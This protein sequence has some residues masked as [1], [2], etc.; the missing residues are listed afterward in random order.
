MKRTRRGSASVVLLVV[1]VAAELLVL[2]RVTGGARD[3]DLSVR[4]LETLRAF[5]AAEGGMNMALREAIAGTDADG[6]GAAGS[7]SSDGNGAND[8]SFSGAAVSVSTTTSAG[9]TVLAS[10]GRA[11]VAARAIQVTLR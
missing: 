7:I 1:V 6:D 2:S 10:R 8:P 11:G 3:H 5:Y 9:Q 4:R